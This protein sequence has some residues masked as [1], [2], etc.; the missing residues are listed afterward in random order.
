MISI[1]LEI[2]DTFYKEKSHKSQTNREL[3]LTLSVITLSKNGL[4][5]LS[6]RKIIRVRQKCIA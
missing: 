4:N 6:K 3:R 1:I 5:Y 2:P